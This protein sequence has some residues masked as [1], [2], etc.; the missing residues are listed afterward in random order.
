MDTSLKAMRKPSHDILSYARFLHTVLL[1]TYHTHC[2]EIQI[3]RYL[4][5]EQN[6]AIY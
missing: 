2:L 4:G 1:Q 6:Y 3:F 5:L